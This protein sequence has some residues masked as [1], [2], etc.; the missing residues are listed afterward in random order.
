MVRAPFG[1]ANIFREPLI[2][3]NVVSRAKVGTCGVMVTNPD[4]VES[5]LD[6]ALKAREAPSAEAM[7]EAL[8]VL[9]AA[10]YLT[11][12]EGRITHFN[13]ACVDFAGRVPQTGAD[14]WCV[15]WRLY[16]DD[17]E[18]MPPEKCPMAMAIRERRPVR[19]VE[20]WAERPDGS[21]VRFRPFPTP[22]FDDSGELVGAVNLL[23]DVTDRHRADELHQQAARCRRLAGT[24]GDRR[25]VEAL[26]AM[27]SEYDEEASRLDRAH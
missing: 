6:A 15:S 19:G 16:S 26:T 22:L 21:R 11:D 7:A 24:V 2:Y 23:I 17:G 4:Q 25:T 1:C 9:P 20:A 8:D 3:I 12:T 10:I 27:A 13:K 14:R 18:P 5:L